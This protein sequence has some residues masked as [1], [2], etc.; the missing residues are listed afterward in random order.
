M[1]EDIAKDKKVVKKA[2]AMH[3]KQSHEGEKTNL[4]KL[5]K[6][7]RMKKEGGCVGRY[8]EGGSIKMKKDAADIKDI[9]KIKLSKTKKA[10]APSAAMMAEPTPFKKGGNVKKYNMGGMASYDQAMQDPKAKKMMRDASLARTLKANPISET[11][12]SSISNSDAAKGLRNY[13]R[14]YKQGMGMKPDTAY[15]YKKGGKAKKCAEGGSLKSV[16][17]EENPGLAKLPTNVRNK[18]G[19]AKKGGEVKKMNVGGR[20]DIEEVKENL[21]MRPGENTTYSKVR[22]IGPAIAASRL[23]ERGVDVPGLIANRARNSSEDPYKKGG[24]VKKYA[25]GGIVDNIKA[26]G[27][28][29]YENVMGTPEQNKAAAEQEKRIAEKDPSSYEAKYRKMTGKKRG[30]KA[31]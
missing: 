11:E 28:K 18:M 5:K 27:K 14:M 30:G 1:S 7:G 22:G 2:F 29:L 9:Q 13:G 25:D 8:K 19:Y 10:A 26:V 20:S 16:D 15:E 17:A 6:G 4:S 23:K 24:K 21:Y 12:L 3:D 31:C